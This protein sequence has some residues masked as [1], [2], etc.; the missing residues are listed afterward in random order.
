MAEVVNLDA[1]IPREDFIA[2]P[3]NA[4]SSAGELGKP[5]ASATDLTARESF[6][7][8]LRKPD[9]QRETA[10]WT[11][12]AVCDFIE[13]FVSNDL[14]PSVICWQSPLSNSPTY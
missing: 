10:A 12:G 9:F 4:S 6:F 14:I 5:S 1:L 7:E 11:P 3:D 8:T 13:A 2:P